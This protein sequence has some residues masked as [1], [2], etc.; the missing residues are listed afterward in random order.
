MH[1][2]KVGVEGV[3][4][5]AVSPGPYSGR[6]GCHLTWTATQK[7]QSPVCQCP[8]PVASAGRRMLVSIGGVT[9]DSGLSSPSIRAG[10]VSQHAWCP[11]P[12]I[13][14]FLSVDVAVVAGFH[15]VLQVPS[16]RSG[17]EKQ[18]IRS[19]VEANIL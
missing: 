16:K 3:V 15:F 9:N 8:G 2:C 17:K 18:D 7:I 12:S 6:L 1:R 5:V 14:I 11:A 4:R 10:L 13:E 19:Y